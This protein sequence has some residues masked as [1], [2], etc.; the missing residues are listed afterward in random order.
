MQDAYQREWKI[1]ENDK[2]IGDFAKIIARI[3]KRKA[4]I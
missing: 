1:D 2:K 4:I 3:D